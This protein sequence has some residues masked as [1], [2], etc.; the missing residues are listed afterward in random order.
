ME[1][2][3]FDLTRYLLGSG[4]GWVIAMAISGLFS[5]LRF[6]IPRPT[7]FPGLGIA[8]LWLVSDGVLLLLALCHKEVYR[9]EIAFITF[10]PLV[11]AAGVAC[12]HK[13]TLG[14]SRRDAFG[15]L[16]VETV[17]GLLAWAVS[18]DS[19]RLICQLFL[20]EDSGANQVYNSILPVLLMTLIIEEIAGPVRRRARTE[21]LP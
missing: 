5:W 18:S 2:S 6:I 4:I 21:S 13:V 19:C 14:L 9:L 7:A 17:L 11:T 20:G 8:F 12:W 10:L 1:E 16:M 3:G 15:I